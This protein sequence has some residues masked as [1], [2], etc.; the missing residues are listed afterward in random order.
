MANICFVPHFVGSWKMASSLDSIIIH[1]SRE[2][3][4][5]PNDNRYH[6]SDMVNGPYKGEFKEFNN[7]W[8]HEIWILQKRHPHILFMYVA[9]SSGQFS[10]LTWS[11]LSAALAILYLTF[12]MPQTLGF[13]PTSL[14]A[15]S[16]TPLLFPPLLPD[17]WLWS[18]QWLVPCPPLFPKLFIP[19]WL[20]LVTML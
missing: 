11:I 2:Q 13:P 7:S 17:L 5:I 1:C 14:T 3:G 9:K 8:A 20:H 6:I 12:R 18:A 19:W 16:L 10:D 4:P 15:P